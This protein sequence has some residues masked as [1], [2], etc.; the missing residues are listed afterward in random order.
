MPLRTATIPNGAEMLCETNGFN[1]SAAN[2][3]SAGSMTSAPRAL[4]ES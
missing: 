3:A 2:G 1:S 4:N